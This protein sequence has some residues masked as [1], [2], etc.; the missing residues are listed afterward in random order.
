MCFRVTRDGNTKTKSIVLNIEDDNDI[1]PVFE[2]PPYEF[3]T[4]E[5]LTGK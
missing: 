4:S 3:D 2:S 5:E 1:S